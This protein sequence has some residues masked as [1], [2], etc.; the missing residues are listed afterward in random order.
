MKS[1]IRSRRVSTWGLGLKS[2]TASSPRYS[3][4]ATLPRPPVAGEELAVLLQQPGQLERLELR[5]LALEDARGRAAGELRRDRQEELVD[6]AERLQ[7]GVQ[8]RA[9]LAEQRPDPAL[10]AQVAQR[11]GEVDRALVA[12]D[13]QRGRRLGG[14]ASEAVKIRTRPPPSVKSGASQGSSRRPLTITI[15]GSGR[16]SSRARVAGRRRAP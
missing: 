7:L 8:A 1:R 3:G 2:T 6:E 4:A 12:D 14:S 10:L 15:S 5:Q 13:L 9:A 16:P 11:R